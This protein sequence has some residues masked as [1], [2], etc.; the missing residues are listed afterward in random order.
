MAT[1]N[2]IFLGQQLQFKTG[3][4]TGHLRFIE[5]NQSVRRLSQEPNSFVKYL[6]KHRK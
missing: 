6:N 3:W 1:N 4:A 5:P 2:F